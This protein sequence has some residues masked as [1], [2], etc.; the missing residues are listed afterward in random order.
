MAR[1]ASACMVFP[2]SHH[3]SPGSRLPA[4]GA[5]INNRKNC[6]ICARDW[7]HTARGN[8]HCKHTHSVYWQCGQK[9]LCLWPQLVLIKVQNT[10]TQNMKIVSMNCKDCNEFFSQFV[11][12]SAASDSR[13]FKC[14]F[15]VVR[16]L[17]FA[18]VRH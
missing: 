4:P 15:L 12:P 5:Y 14:T 11:F 1:F 7:T 17:L 16:C 6:V 8:S 2:I 18:V 13:S 3:P 9:A 10:H